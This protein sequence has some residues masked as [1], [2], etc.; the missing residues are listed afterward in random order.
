MTRAEKIISTLGYAGLIPFIAACALLYFGAEAL[1]N[2]IF[3]S[4]SAIIL[5]FLGG[6]HWGR[7]IAS[8][9]S[10]KVGVGLLALLASNVFALLGWSAL[11]LSQSGSVYPFIIL[12]TGFVMLFMVEVTAMPSIVSTVHRRYTAFRAFL[13]ITVLLL[14]GVFIL[15]SA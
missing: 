11:L 10:L 8:D 4:Y 15:L 1:A 13:T 3:L 5:S 14:H 6:T 7:L 12:T 9:I 2:Q